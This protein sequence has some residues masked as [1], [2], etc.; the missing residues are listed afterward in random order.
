MSLPLALLLLVF[1]C[2]LGSAVVMLLGLPSVVSTTLGVL[3]GC[4]LGVRLE[5]LK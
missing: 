4:Y 5:A 2:A 1:W 3:G